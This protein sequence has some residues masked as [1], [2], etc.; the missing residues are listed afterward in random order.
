MKTL[1]CPF[2]KEHIT[3]QPEEIVRQKV[4]SMMTKSLGYPQGYIVVEKSLSQL[5]QIQNNQRLVLPNR[6]LDILVYAPNKENNL[7]PFLL[8]ECKAVPFNSKALQQV[9]G[10]NHYV[11]ANFISV[12]N[13]EQAIVGW[14]DKKHNGYRHINF[15]PTYNDLYHSLFSLG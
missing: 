3:A 9:A 12:V 5:P 7:T 6:R 8:I 14:F 1:Y 11:G 4:L 10:Y 13:A 15:L 2:R